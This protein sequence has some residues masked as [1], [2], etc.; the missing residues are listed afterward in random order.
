[1][2]TP[3]P[4]DLDQCVARALEEDLGGGDLTASLV[5]A[6]ATSHA[7]IV[8]REA[9]VLAGRPY[10]DAVFRRLD[11]GIE[12]KWSAEDGESIL[13]GQVLC[14]LRGSSRALLTGERTALN[15]LQ[16]LS[17]TAT[18]AARFVEAVAGT[19][20]TVMDTRKTLPGLRLAQK[21]AVRCGGAANHRLG[22]YDGILIK[23]NHIAAAGSIGAAVRRARA[24]GAGVPVE[25][26]VESLE[27]LGLALDAEADVVMLDDF[28]LEDMVEAVRLNRARPR[29]A[30]LEASG[31]VDLDSVRR[32]AATGVDY[33]SVG[34]I[35]KHVR[36]VDLSM[37][38]GTALP[39]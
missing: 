10:A 39:A 1:M 31:G 30:K 13:A 23:E 22:L 12:L 7:T 27:E 14:R 17:A 21:Y 8:S 33:V 19:A 28:T 26:E 37:R 25:V 9:A 35:T 32:V 5:P 11:P 18:A 34:G 38:F 4:P 20:C 29:P 36:A 2:N 3:I 6:G 16:T 24:T 15:F